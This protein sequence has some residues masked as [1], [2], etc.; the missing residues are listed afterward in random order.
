MWPV[1]GL[2]LLASA[3]LRGLLGH[4]VAQVGQGARLVR[5]ASRGC[6]GAVAICAALA[7]RLIVRDGSQP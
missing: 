4:A 5:G 6:G 1:S 2:S 7:V 3:G